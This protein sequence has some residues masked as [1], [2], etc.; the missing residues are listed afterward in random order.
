MATTHA[1]KKV[2]WLQR[3]CSDIG[4]MQKAMKIDYGSQSAICLAKNPTFH[5]RS[6]HIDVQ[7]HFVREMVK[8]NK[9]LL[10][11]FDTLKNVVNSLTKS[12]STKKFSWCRKSMGIAAFSN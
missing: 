7:Y 12:V 4:F 9:V 8:E 11:K 3:L 10:Q 2:V 6:K 5:A 1:C